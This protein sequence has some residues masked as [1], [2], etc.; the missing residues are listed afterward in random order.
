MTIQEK[1]TK[2]SSRNRGP[3]DHSREANESERS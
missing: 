2:A 3:N 1:K